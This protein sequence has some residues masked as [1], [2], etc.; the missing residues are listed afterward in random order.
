MNLG[1]LVDGMDMGKLGDFVFYM[2][3]NDYKKIS[4]NLKRDYGSFK[5]IKGQEQLNDAGGY[6]RTLTLNG[7]L[8]LQ[9]LDALKKLDDFLIDGKP[10]RFTTLTVDFDVV[11]TSLNT[12]KEHFTDNGSHTVINYNLSLKEVYDDIQ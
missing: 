8:V 12:T 5:P 6:S 1:S 11:L 2:N 9:P 7:V 3:K 10:L 4:E